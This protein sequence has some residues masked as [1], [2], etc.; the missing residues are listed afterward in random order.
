MFALCDKIIAKNKLKPHR[1]LF[2]YYTFSS[3]E[4]F[5][6]VPETDWTEAVKNHNLFLCYNYLK[7][8]HQQQTTH[9]RFR[10]TII[11]NRKIPVGVVY[12]QIN[13]FSAGLF[14]NIIEKQWQETDSKRTSVFKRYIEGNKDETIMRL[15][16]CGNNF[17]SGE[18][19]FFININS[20][21]TKFKLVEKIIDCVSRE[22]KLRGKISAILV[23]DFYE[24]GFG[25]KE[26]WHCTRY[27]H[28]NVEPNMIVHIP[29]NTASLNDYITLFSKK[30]RQRYKHIAQANNLLQKKRLTF[31]EAV[32]YNDSLHNLYLQVFEH[33]KFKFEALKKDY[34]LQLLKECPQLFFIDAWFYNEELVSFASGFILDTEI[35]AHYIGFDYSKNKEL[36]LYQTILY[37]FIEEGIKT[38]KTQINLGRTASEIKSTVGAKA[39][40]L[41]CYLKPQNTL[42]KLI[43]KP[44]MQFL[45][46][47]EWLP[48]NPFKE[49]E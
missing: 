30:Y 39:H 31:E 4:D 25:N 48:R 46:P 47:S 14:S 6:L 29:Q 20:K 24:E 38:Q 7:V 22:E 45:Q 34:F 5:N 10:Y 18:H 27:V 16:T 3:Y 19:G 28:F 49:G 42:S 44:F 33:A 8:I 17:V 2:G 32:K 26:C 41:I 37:N 36:E 11:Y 15:I 23:K 1:K 12:F 13:D 35:E 43:L 40:A 21:E 9:F